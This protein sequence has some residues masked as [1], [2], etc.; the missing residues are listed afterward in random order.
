MISRDVGEVTI[1]IRRIDDN[2]FFGQIGRIERKI[3]KEFFEERIETTRANILRLLVDRL[4]KLRQ[5][6]D[7]V[8]PK[9]QRNALCSKERRILL[10]E[11]ILWLCENAL[12]ILFDK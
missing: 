3:L 12:K 9:G 5:T 7:C 10:D 11:R 6:S 8:V 1:H 4:G 2:V